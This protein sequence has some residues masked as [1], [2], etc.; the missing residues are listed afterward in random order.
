MLDKRRRR[1]LV[2]QLVEARNE[3]GFSQKEV[4]KLSGI[5]QSKL[6]KI[7]NGERNIRFL[8]LEDLASIYNKPLDHFKTT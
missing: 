2:K 7:E 6:S 1:E 8:E 3:S 5:S 4:E